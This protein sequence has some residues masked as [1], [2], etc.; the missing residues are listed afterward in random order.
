MIAPAAASRQVQRLHLRAPDA[1]LARRGV[2]LLEDALRTASLPD[3]GAR[4]LVFRRLVLERFGSGVSPQTLSLALERR[5]AELRGQA[6]HA[7]APGAAQAAAIWFRDA[8]EAHTLLAQRIAEESP[9][10][11]WFW[12]AVVPEIERAGSTAQRLR[13]VMRSLARL[14]EA[15][16]AMSLLACALAQR[17]HADVLRTAVGA[18]EAARLL[19][20]DAVGATIAPPRAAAIPP[21]LDAPAL[22]H[23]VAAAH[24]VERGAEFSS[25]PTARPL[26]RARISRGTE[27]AWLSGA[28]PPEHVVPTRLPM[29]PVATPV[30]QQRSEDAAGITARSAAIDTMAD[31]DGAA[32]QHDRRADAAAIEARPCAPAHSLSPRAAAQPSVCVTSG[33]ASRIAAAPQ[34]ADAPSW[35]RLEQPAWPAAAPTEAGGLLFLL[36]VLARLGYA[37]WLEAMPEWEPLRIDRRVLALVC[38]RLAPAPDDPAWLL[39]AAPAVAPPE[40]YCAPSI[41]ID[42]VADCSAA[43]RRYVAADGTRLCDAGGRLL[44]AAWPGRRRPA[45]FAE[46][47]RGRDVVRSGDNRRGADLTAAVAEAWLT[48]CRRWLRR[49]A[50]VGVAGLVMRPARLSLTPTH[51]DMFFGLSDV[52][53]AVRR[54]GLDLDPGWVRWFRRV[55]GFHYGRTPWK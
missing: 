10:S 20:A 18:G 54:A 51:V 35:G 48:A 11:E 13:V 40:R 36:S 12:P 15:P 27:A 50:R 39:C 19:Q 43:W 33:P 6:V 29:Q 16:T 8:L 34:A 17:G 46:M 5:V 37:Q 52:S 41:W 31:K 25:T 38:A 7:M 32:Q 1:T 49:C 53:L 4:M 28:R 44:L 22:H 55:V 21:L 47:L 30:L 14:P 26:L 9:V 24:P 42:A 3:A 45:A 2:R 23:R